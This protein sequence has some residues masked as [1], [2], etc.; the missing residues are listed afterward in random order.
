MLEH[1]RLKIV[2][3]FKNALFSLSNV[4][5]SVY[6]SIQENLEEKYEPLEKATLQKA[7]G[8]NS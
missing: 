5:T 8:G 6:G 4:P 1:N 2:N 3:Q 7:L